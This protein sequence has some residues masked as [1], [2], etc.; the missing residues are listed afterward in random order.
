MIRKIGIALLCIGLGTSLYARDDISESTTFIGLEVGYVEVQGDVGYL[1]DDM[2]VIEPNFVGDYDVQYGFRIGAQRDQWRTT[3]IYD[4][5]DSKDNDQN[6]EQGYLTLDYFILEKESA[7]RPY[8]GLNV[9]YGNYESTF[10]DESGFLYGG[11][12]GIVLEVAETINLDVGFRYTLSN[13]D[14]FD[15]I[16]GVIFGANY[17]F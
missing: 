8:I 4:Y 15:H 10:V 6:V 17:L 16:G 13:A 11:Q 2:P 14:S 12:V 1:I 9:G 3:L 5:Y 7:F